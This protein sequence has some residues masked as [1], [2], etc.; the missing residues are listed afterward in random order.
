MKTLR[1]K[2]ENLV[3]DIGLTEHAFNFI[4]SAKLQP[5]QVMSNNYNEKI[6]I[7][8]KNPA[9]KDLIM[10]SSFEVGRIEKSFQIKNTKENEELNTLKDVMIKRKSTRSYSKK[11]S[12][13]ELFTLLSTAYFQHTKD[14]QKRRNIASGGG[15]YPI[16]LFYF[17]L[18]TTGLPRGLYHY[19]I[20][21][22]SLDLLNKM[23][24]E[25]L[26]DFMTDAYFTD[27]KEDIDY[28]E[29][30]GIIVFAGIINKASF[31][32]NDFGLK[33]AYIDTGAILN[34]LWLTSAALGIGCVACGGYNDALFEK[35]LE[36]KAWY[37][38][39]VT[40]MIIGKE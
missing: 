21:R 8:N 35:E 20:T 22:N 6:A 14:N 24:K 3:F 39:V 40:T 37:H 18:N 4:E 34:N 36:F 32:Y 5:F 2:L 31:K 27:Y 25:A 28:L 17:N 33:L 23:E 7:V 9:Y 1:D 12:K 30:S 38:N 15:T 10:N 26:E 11:V 13:E 19:N 16:E 29:A